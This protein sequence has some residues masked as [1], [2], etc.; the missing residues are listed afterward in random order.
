MPAY[1]IGVDSVTWGEWRSDRGKD[2]FLIAS[3]P[4][5]S[6]PNY[7]FMPPSLPSYVDEIDLT[8]ADLIGDSVFASGHG[9]FPRW[10]ETDDPIRRSPTNWRWSSGFFGGVVIHLITRIGTYVQCTYQT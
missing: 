2:G 10:L 4:D 9:T 6:T 7:P 3:I 1:L 5:A 8:G